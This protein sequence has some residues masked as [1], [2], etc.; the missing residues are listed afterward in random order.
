MGSFGIRRW[1]FPP[2]GSSHQDPDMTCAGKCGRRRHDGNEKRRYDRMETR[3]RSG[4][5]EKMGNKAMNC[6]AQGNKWKLA[7]G[8]GGGRR[9]FTVQGVEIIFYLRVGPHFSRLPAASATPYKARTQ[10]KISLTSIFLQQ[11]MPWNLYFKVSKN[12]ET[13]FLW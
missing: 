8:R 6:L 12:F 5:V 4:R 10:F 11:I 7:L 9:Q 2:G 3:G 1:C 13:K